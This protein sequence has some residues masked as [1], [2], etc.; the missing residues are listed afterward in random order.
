VSSDATPTLEFR[1]IEAAP[2]LEAHV[3]HYWV[4]LGGTAAAAAHPVFPDGCSEIVF[5]LG[6]LTHERQPSGRLTVQPWA[7]L[8]GQMTR[9]LDIVPGGTLRMVGIKLAPWGAAAILGEASAAVRDRTLALSDIDPA[10]PLQIGDQLEACRGDDEVGAVLDRALRARLAVVG[11]RR[12][13]GLNRFARSWCAS[14]GPSVGALA[15]AAG[16]SA[17]TVE[18]HFERFVGLSPKEFSRVRRFQRALRLAREQPVLHWSTIAARAGYSDQSHLGRDFR[19][20]AGC[21]PTLVAPA[22]TPIT[23]AFL[24]DEG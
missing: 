20:F 17:R 1:C 11:T 9:P 15:R 22:S 18:R 16:Y 3:R 19:Q 12:L 4:L 13:D 6:S 8:V 24:N 23:A 5:N 7:M 14:P 21:A 2:D 10:L